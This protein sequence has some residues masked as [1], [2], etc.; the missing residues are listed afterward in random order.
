[1]RRKNKK[2]QKKKQAKNVDRTQSVKTNILTR[3]KRRLNRVSQNKNKN[4]TRK[5]CKFQKQQKMAQ[6]SLSINKMALNF[7]FLKQIKNTQLNV[8]RY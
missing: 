6:I 5:K 1:M 4:I 8:V 3:K 7:Y 2:K